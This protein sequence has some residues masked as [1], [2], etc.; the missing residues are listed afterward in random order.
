MVSRFRNIKD[1][2][3]GDI[4]LTEYEKGVLRFAYSR[5][6]TEKDVRGVCSRIP[7]LEG[8]GLGYDS[9]GIKRIGE[10]EW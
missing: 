9:D 6:P 1:K 8:I 2:E 7:G 3:D 5:C 4:V 10:N